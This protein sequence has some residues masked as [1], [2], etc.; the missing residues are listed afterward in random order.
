[1]S[2]REE[3]LSQGFLIWMELRWVILREV[4]LY[5]SFCI[6]SYL[7]WEGPGVRWLVLEIRPLETD[8]SLGNK[9]FPPPTCCPLQVWS[10][11][12]ALPLGVAE[13]QV[14]FHKFSFLQCCLASRSASLA[15]N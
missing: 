3:P 9:G 14:R 15:A 4:W 1:M 8:L 11:A 5:W 2:R 12:P 10:T 13:E 6:K 7:D